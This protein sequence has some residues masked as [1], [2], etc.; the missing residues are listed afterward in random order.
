L[1]SLERDYLLMTPKSKGISLVLICVS[2]WA[3]IPVVAKLGQTTLDNHQFLFWSSLVS[4]IVL[5][6]VSVFNNRIKEIKQ[7]RAKDWFYLF[8]LGLLGTYIYYLLL[9]LG[10]SK[11]DGLEVLVFQ[12]SWPIL[13]VLFSIIILKEKLNIN[14]SIALILGFIGVLFVLTKGEFQSINVSNP[15]IAILVLLGAASFALFSVLSKNIKQD[16]LVAVTI[17]FFSAT[18]ASF[19]SMMCFSE[20]TTPTTSEIFPVLLNGIIVNGFSYL[21]WIKALKKT[22]ASYLAPFTFLTPVLSAI[23]LLIFFNEPFTSANLIGLACIVAS[24][25]INSVKSR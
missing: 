16:P 23:Y 8:F 20:F 5:G 3:L 17:Y 2:M 15:N 22:E 19:I 12:Y 14:K 9:Y 24:G 10:Y 6:L 25:L 13:T 18:I 7:Y 21:L 1:G 4:F 11:S